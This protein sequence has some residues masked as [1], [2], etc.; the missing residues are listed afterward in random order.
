MWGPTDRLRDPE[1]TIILYF[2]NGIGNPIRRIHCKTR[3]EYDSSQ[4]DKKE[5][6]PRRISGPMS[7]LK[8]GRQKTFVR[9][10]GKLI[11]NFSEKWRGMHSPNSAITQLADRN[12]PAELVP[13]QQVMGHLGQKTGGIR[14]HHGGIRARKLGASGGILGNPGASGVFWADADLKTIWE[15]P[16]KCQLSRGH[17]PAEQPFFI[18]LKREN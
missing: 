10:R 7:P 4:L 6:D 18:I 16:H 5:I 17:P 1:I 13:G 9:L 12:V 8:T 3:D 2:Q 11:Y 14:G 15:F